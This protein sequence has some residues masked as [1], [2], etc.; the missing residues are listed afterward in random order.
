[1]LVGGLVVALI[2][3]AIVAGTS[4][5]GD[6]QTASEG[7][8][9]EQNP[10]TT[11]PQTTT[12]DEPEVTTSTTAAPAGPTTV[13]MGQPVEIAIDEIEFDQDE[14]YATVTLANPT[15]AEGALVEYGIQPEYGLWLVVDA[16]VAVSPESA[17]TYS[18]SSGEFHF[19]GGD[20][21]VFSSTYAG[22]DQEFDYYDLSAGQ[23]AAGKLVFD[24][25]PDKLAGGKVQLDDTYEDYGE[26]LAFWMV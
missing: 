8:T 21:T 7:D 14:T 3:G 11:E 10:E 23:K 18:I 4:G 17:G 19:V 2:I 5:D 13:A 25:A 20:G 16:T 22:I 26:P 24:I 1:L 6:T 9:T 15:T 12:T